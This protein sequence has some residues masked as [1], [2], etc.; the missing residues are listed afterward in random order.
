[1]SWVDFILNIAG[2][3]LWLNWRAGKIDPLGKRTPATLVG[4]LRRAEPSRARRWTL[5]LFLGAFL[6]LRA[7]LYWQVGSALH[8]AGTLNLGVISLSFRS[9]WF[10]RALV[11][12]ILSFLLALGILYS[13]LL[14][15]SLLKGPKPIQDFVRLQLGTID[16]WPP[17]MKLVLPFVVTAVAWWAVSW[18]LVGLGI[19]PRP[20]SPVVR[21]EES[22]IIGLQSYLLWEFPVAALLVLHLLNNYIYFGR[23][24]VWNYADVTAN[25]LLS[26][27]RRLKWL[28]LRIG[29]VD[30]T[31]VLGIAVVFFGAQLAG[32]ILMRLYSRLVL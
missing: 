26:P 14:L 19:I 16:D 29:K 17:A 20:V 23:H 9:D 24:P 32:Q 31:P 8:W 22:L 27:L 12:S 5:P 2:L 28:P 25:T 10:G 11:F 4:T 1:M 18:A 7:L 15:L 30:L 6:F 21:I 3:L 13:C